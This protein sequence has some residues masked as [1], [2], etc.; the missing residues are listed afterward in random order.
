MN[1]TLEVRVTSTFYFRV[2]HYSCPSVCIGTNH[3]TVLEYVIE[4]KP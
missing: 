3:V 4:D 2:K 1:Y